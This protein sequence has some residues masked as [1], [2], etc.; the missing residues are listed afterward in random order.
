MSVHPSD[1]VSDSLELTTSS[2]LLL[3]L[4]MFAVT[5]GYSMSEK[6]PFLWERRLLAD[7]EVEVNSLN[8]DCLLICELQQHSESI[9]VMIHS[10][11]Q[12]GVI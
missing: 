5:L 2:F 10:Q 4:A 1:S 11:Q 12:D 8:T 9:A 6:A 7:R 3:L